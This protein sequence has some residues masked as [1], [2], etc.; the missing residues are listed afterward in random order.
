MVKILFTAVLAVAAQGV[1]AADFND[2]Q[3]LKA[4]NIAK[5]ANEGAVLSVPAADNAAG[6]PAKQVEWVAINGGKFMMGNDSLAEAKPSHEVTVKAFEMS[7]SVVT[8]EQYA[9]CVSK[10]VCSE[11][12]TADMD[13][14]NFCNWGLAD[15]KDNPVNCLDWD[16]A[17]QYARF[18]GARLP[19]EAEWE[20]AAK[21]G[22]KDQAY[23]W[24]NDAPNCDNVVMYAGAYC[25]RIYT[26]PVCSKPAG[27]TAQGLCDMAGNVW[28]WVEDTYQGSYK[29]APVDGSAVEGQGLRVMRGG[30]FPW[31]TPSYFRTD[32]RY[33]MERGSRSSYVG[34]RI[35]R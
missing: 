14:E 20:Y 29:G 21:S 2:L 3:A 17:N 13:N 8:V 1:Y 22:G 4:N 15:R 10:G 12:V 16:Q 5:A 31:W 25:S 9:E 26:A 18:K 33:S 34:F 32:D 11:P 24:G 23:P 35:A 30:E 6:A 19:T 7:K 28:Q 27:N